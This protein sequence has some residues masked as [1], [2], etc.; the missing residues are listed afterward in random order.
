M[1][2]EAA[3][4]NAVRT[5]RD[6]HFG[7]RDISCD[8]TLR[9]GYHSRQVTQVMWPETGTPVSGIQ[10]IEMA[11]STAGVRGAAVA[12]FMHMKTMLGTWRKSAQLN[13]HDRAVPSLENRRDS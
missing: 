1:D 13:A 9:I 11:A 5:S 6:G 4:D 12:L 2:D 8:T 3:T 7:Q 10:R